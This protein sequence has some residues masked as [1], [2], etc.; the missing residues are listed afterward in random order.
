[1]W[2]I[3][4]KCQNYYFFKVVLSCVIFLYNSFNLW[5]N[6]LH[7]I[8]V[9]LYLT[10]LFSISFEMS[11][12]IFLAIM[13]LMN[14]SKTAYLSVKC[15]TNTN[16]QLTYQKYSYP[17]FYKKT[18]KSF[19]FFFLRTFY[20]GRRVIMM[21]R[22]IWYSFLQPVNSCFSMKCFW[23]LDENYV[24]YQPHWDTAQ[25]QEFFQPLQCNNTMPNR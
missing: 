10:H 21:Y 19:L 18:S 5:D 20:L 14:T 13:Q 22:G 15:R 23:Q 24:A 8:L 3:G 6:I 2:S 12:L 11:C 9:L 1:M 16:W 4:I 17:R 25:P 7:L